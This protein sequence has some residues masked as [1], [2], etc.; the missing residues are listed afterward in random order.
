VNGTV[1]SRVARGLAAAAVS[2][3]ARL[4]LFSGGAAARQQSLGDQLCK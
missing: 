2:P 4:R 3:S 1:A